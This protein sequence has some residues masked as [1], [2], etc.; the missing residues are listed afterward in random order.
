ME[1]RIVAPDGETRLRLP[2]PTAIPE[3]VRAATALPMVSHR[4][5]EFRAILSAS[6]AMLRAVLGTEQDVFILGA[7]GSGGM[8]AA[9]VNCLSSGD[10]LLVVENGQF[11]ERFSTIAETLPVTID[12]L[13][14]PWGE[15]PDPAEIAARVKAKRYC[16]VVVVHNES[17][18]GAVADLANIGRVLRDTDTLLVVDSVSGVGGID[19]QMDQWGVDVAITASQK[20]LMCPPGLAII[21]LS[22]K[23]LQVVNRAKGI[24][25][26]YF[27]FRRAKASLDKGETPFTPPVSLI[28]GLHEALTMM[29]EEGLPAVLER[30]ALLSK[31]LAAGFQALGLPIF[32][33]SPLT[34]HT[35][36]VGAVP[37]GIEGSA[38][39]RHMFTQHHTVIAGQR[40]KLANRVIRIGTMGLV[41][42]SDILTDLFYL[43]D[44]LRTLGQRPSPGAGVCAAMA[45][46]AP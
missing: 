4:G 37:A 46:L 23:A 33:A 3:R 12:R 31:A 1:T 36:I 17:A 14:I 13:Q 34:S 27:D 18:T 9:L 5:P 8:E 7:S 42:P 11:G 6:S 21:A 19:F 43:E 30:H 2:G 22:A 26:F 35:V 15:A 28:R 40:T 44:T 25:R 20:C 39:V 24:P 41:T 45:I 16:A 32:P 10:T 29:H 38:I